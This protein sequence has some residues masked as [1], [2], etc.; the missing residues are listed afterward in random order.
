MRRK[1]KTHPELTNIY[2]DNFP[3]I[4]FTV[5]GYFLSLA[6]TKD[7][8]KNESTDSILGGDGKGFWT[9]FPN[10]GKYFT[11]IY[12][13][14]HNPDSLGEN[15]YIAFQRLRMG[16]DGFISFA[17]RVQKLLPKPYDPHCFHYRNDEI[18]PADF[19]M[20][21]ITAKKEKLTSSG[22]HPYRSRTEC[23]LYCM[24]RLLN[25]NRCGNLYSSYTEELISR[26]S[27]YRL[28]KDVET[29]L[30]KYINSPMKQI[31]NQYYS[32]SLMKFCEKSNKNEFMKAKE[33][34]LN[35]CPTNCYVENFTEDD[36]FMEN[37]V[38]KEHSRLTIKWAAKNVISLRHK[39]KVIG[40]Q[41]EL[42]SMIGGSV[43]FFLEVSLLYLFIFLIHFFESVNILST[44][45]FI[46]I[47]S[48]WKQKFVKPPNTEE[49]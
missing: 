9:S 25:T 30:S 38:P 22:L 4:V 48:K 41:S 1:K 44:N 34:C 39:P 26:E 19:D 46:N 5:K 16:Y 42:L 12:F 24:H 13:A 11:G 31:K 17:R 40:N 21:T 28:Q 18:S 47:Y 37:P 23:Y 14:V 3:E 35:T 15:T 32:K 29:N 8:T 7:F 6:Q 45:S 20:S 36:G 10:H 33:I 2:F 43:F 49:N 27:L